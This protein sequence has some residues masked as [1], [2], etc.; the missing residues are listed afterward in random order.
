MKGFRQWIARAARAT[1]RL[2]TSPFELLRGIFPV[3]MGEPPPLN[4]DKLLEGYDSMP[5][6]R[7]VAEKVGFAVAAAEWQLFAIK[8]G[9]RTVRD[10]FVQHATVDARTKVLAALRNSGNLR[11]ITDHP[12]FDA[13]NDPNPFMGLIGLLKLT[14]IHID[15]VGDAYW[16][17]ERNKLGVVAGFWPIPPHWVMWHPTPG[18]PTYKIGYRA[19][20]AE[21]PEREIVWFHE[22]SPANPFTR[23]SGIGWCL[24]DE[25]EVDEYAAKFAKALFHNQARPDFVVYGFDNPTEKRRVERD[26]VNRLQGF[27]RA[28]Q[29]YFM[30]GEPKFHEFQRPTMDQL[31]YPSLRKAQ[32]DIVLQTWGVAP[33][34]FGIVESSNRATI[35]AAEYLVARWVVTP[36]VERIRTVLQK[37]FQDEYDERGVLHFKS[38]VPQDKQFILQVAKAAPHSRKVDEWR[39]MQELPPV[40]GA[41]GDAFLVPLNSRITDDLLE[42]LQPPALPPAPKKGSAA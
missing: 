40:G 16:V 18:R 26:W 38:P 34:W 3:A 14:A 33:E 12:F 1:S 24:G 39:A 11:E 30:T 36:R 13:L 32:R 20:Q 8:R 37:L 42:Q 23:G 9:G 17:K 7:A 27:F 6:L 29:P 28:H 2:L 25:L 35:D 15:L 31:V 5:W 21:I 41:E 22:P 19:W 4:T 10:P